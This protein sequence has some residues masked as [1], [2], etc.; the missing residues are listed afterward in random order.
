M[1][2]PELD[3]DLNRPL[4]EIFLVFV[5]ADL[6]GAVDL[7]H[8]VGKRFADALDQLVE[9]RFPLL[10]CLFDC[11]IEFREGISDFFQSSSK[12]V[13]SL[14]PLFE[15]TDHAS[16]SFMHEL[17]SRVLGLDFNIQLLESLIF[18][19]AAEELLGSLVCVGQDLFD[20]FDKFSSLSNGVFVSF[21]QLIN[22]AG[23]GFEFMF[24]GAVALGE[25]LHIGFSFNEHNLCFVK[26][27]VGLSQGL[28]GFLCN[29]Q[30]TAR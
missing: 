8:V 6:A 28:D 24:D 27:V 11:G 23:F 29:S 9:S 15:F 5:D 4:V 17:Q 19:S 26:V 12:T 18:G 21:A 13:D 22:F 20:P 14:L 3:S 10:A 2:V 30:S 16:V 7:L 1:I 25:N